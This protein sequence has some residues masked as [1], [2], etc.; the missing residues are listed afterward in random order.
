MLLLAKK[1]N[2]LGLNDGR[3]MPMPHAHAV[4]QQDS[5]R[6]VAPGNPH[7]HPV[8]FPDPQITPVELIDSARSSPHD[9]TINPADQ[10]DCRNGAP[11][12]PPAGAM[13]IGRDVVARSVRWCT[14]NQAV[15]RWMR[16]YTMSLREIFDL[17]GRS[18]MKADSCAR[19]SGRVGSG[20]R[21][22]KSPGG[23]LD[24]AAYL[25]LTR[26]EEPSPSSM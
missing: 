23:T 5:R 16:V 19:G 1:K 7:R 4:T 25:S 24:P 11:G 2:P 21:A 12:S 15:P 20:D 17:S 14:E 10:S 9:L 13:A 8:Q 26:N 18:A 22:S 3:A 6:V